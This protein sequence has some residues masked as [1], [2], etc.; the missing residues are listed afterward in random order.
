M[1]F[2][3]F[4]SPSSWYYASD[5]FPI[6]SADFLCESCSFNSNEMAAKIR[7]WIRRFVLCQCHFFCF[8][9][10]PAGIM[11]RTVSQS[12]R[13][14]FCANPARLIV[15]RWQQKSVCKY[16]VSFCVNVIFSVLIPLQL[17]SSWLQHLDDFLVVTSIALCSRYPQVLTDTCGY[18]PTAGNPQMYRYLT[19]WGGSPVGNYPSG[20]G[21]GFSIWKYLRVGS[22]STRRL[23][24]GAP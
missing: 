9:P 13:L 4:W 11:P 23:T 7:L 21:F 8:D 5:G 20:S 22:G 14:I 10:P 12:F 19:C 24:R 18:L 6:V 3:L 16:V 2:F 17:V 15:T 1:S